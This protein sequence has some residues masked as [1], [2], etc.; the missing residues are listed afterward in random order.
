LY[1]NSKEMWE[2]PE[3]PHNSN[4]LGSLDGVRVSEWKRL[5]NIIQNPVLFDGKIEP[6]DA[7][8]GLLGD[9]YFLS[10]ISALAEKDHRIKA[11]FGEQ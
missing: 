1:K 2:D 4:S 6:Q 5:S 3:F 10:A 11:I 9:C 7:I 8:Q